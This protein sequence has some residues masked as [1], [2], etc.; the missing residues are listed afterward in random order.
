MCLL[1]FIQQFLCLFY[2]D[3]IMQ[4]QSRSYTTHVQLV[5]QCTYLYWYIALILVGPQLETAPKL[6]ACAPNSVYRWLPLCLDRSSVAH[7]QKI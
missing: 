6:D 1:L 7:A 5:Q 2:Y 3:V 4:P